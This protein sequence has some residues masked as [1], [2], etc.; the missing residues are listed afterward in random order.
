[1]L[2]GAAS[3]AALAT[4][5]KASTAF[6]APAVVQSTG[7]TVTVKYWTAFGG[8]V[9]GT[10]QKK[11]VDDFHASQSDIKIKM[12]AQPTYEDVASALTANLQ[13][14]NAPD[15]AVLSDVWWFRFYLSQSIADLNP[16]VQKAKLD[17]ADYVQSLYK[18]YT[19]HGGQYAIPFSRSTPLFYYNEDALTA[20]GLTPEVF[21]TWSGFAQVASKLA[22]GKTKFAFGLGNAANYGAWVLQ[23]PT[24]A[25][26]GH[27]SD[28]QF[29]ITITEPN[30]L[31][32][33]EF[34]RKAVEDKWATCTA[35]PITDFS[36]GL[37]AAALGSTGDMGTIE[38][39]AKFKFGAAFLPTEKSFGC[40][41]GGAGLSILA[42][43]PDE[44]KQ[45]AL[46]FIDFCTNTQNTAQ[47]SQTTGYMPV[48][49]SAINSAEMQA[50]YAKDPNR[51]VAV[52][53][54]PKCSPQDSARV[55]IPDGDQI[56]GHGWE[57]ILVN[58]KAAKDA[59]GDV[60]AQLDQDKVP[61]LAQI[62]KLE[63]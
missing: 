14:G 28:P 19:R 2:R 53:Q 55:F 21:K 3:A 8:G 40:C 51:K 44:V 49:T 15:L 20:A 39:T 46:T 45:A 4:F 29:D 54:L 48:R 24:W 59:F 5:G 10:A 33:G 27:Y 31:T 56:I 18:D 58:D 7:S 63:G 42:K 26:G 13:T 62:K 9:N 38:Q 34:F 57:Q 23:G 30:A 11:L 41:T 60:K 52:E 22:G 36:T 37:T 35:D 32:C 47:W 6:A 16:L 61:V 43:S 50:L 25:F 12:E 1:V 17:T